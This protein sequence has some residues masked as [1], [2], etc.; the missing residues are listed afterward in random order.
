MATD[1]SSD[2]N[3]SEMLGHPSGLFVLF[4]VELWERFSFY[5]M[6]ALLVFYM[7]KQLMF[8]D[9]MSYG[10]YGAYGSLVYATPVIGG[11]LADRL[12]GYRR[13]IL[14]GAILMAFGHFAMAFDYETISAMLGPMATE[15][16]TNQLDIAVAGTSFTLDTTIFF[17][18]AL[19]LLIIGNGFFKPNISSLVG[20]LYDDDAVDEGKRDG[21]FTIFYMGINIGALLAPLTCG[22]I[23]ETWGWH[24]GFGLAGIGMVTG[25]IIFIYFQDVLGEYGYS[26]FPEK[27]DANFPPDVKRPELLKW[28][29]VSAV[30]G[31]LFVV[32]SA[33]LGATVETI[34]GAADFGVYLEK[35]F[36]LLGWL[37]V[38]LAIV[39]AAFSFLSN[40]HATYVGAVLAVPNIAYLVTRHDVMGGLLL[41]LGVGVLGSL[42]AFALR[43]DKVDRERLF[44]VLVLIFFSMTFWAF[45]EQAGSSINLFTDRNVDRSLF[46]WTVPASVFQGVNPAFI[47][48][49]APVFAW[50]WEKLKGV[51]LEPST[52][53]KFGLGILQLGLGFGMLVL[54]TV[55]ATQD[56]MVAIWFLLLGYMLHTTGE[57]CL[58]PVGL[59][60]VTKLSPKATVGVVMG[61]WFLSS[62][63]A[64]YI[65]GLFAKLASA[66]EGSSMKEMAATETLPIYAGLFGNIAIIAGVV[67]VLCLL[68]SPILKKWM[69]GVN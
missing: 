8:T 42:F 40:K 66:P 41:L 55:F 33:Q 54:G 64:H 10:I 51:D 14:I 59:S 63:F 22:A 58:S 20:R 49:L 68:L 11:L 12:L 25:L 67:G 50:L 19:A 32:L 56:G 43:S 69:H 24:Y 45:F 13:A 1:T 29:G 15:V 5:G 37:G 34:F 48:L 62:S 6:R 9:T 52:P 4:F 28:V 17:Y 26:P 35:M 39:A 53:V 27:L 30:V 21:G 47:I 18:G 36:E 31:V 46:G 7:T 61:A 44:V 3:P 16:G 2:G 23:G 60:M 65:A 57:L 38:E